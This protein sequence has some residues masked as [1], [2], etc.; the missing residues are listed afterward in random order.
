MVPSEAEASWV[1]P[2]SSLSIELVVANINAL[3]RPRTH[4]G[5]EESSVVSVFNE[6]S[7]LLSFVPATDRRSFA[8]DWPTLLPKFTAVVAFQPF[9]YPHVAT[10]IFKVSA[11]DFLRRL[12]QAHQHHEPVENKNGCS[13][14]A[15]LGHATLEGLLHLGLVHSAIDIAH[16]LRELETETA[17]KIDDDCASTFTPSNKVIA[18]LLHA[19]VELDGHELQS[20]VLTCHQ[21]FPGWLQHFSVT[22]DAVLL[23][24]ILRYAVF[25]SNSGL[26]KV[27]LHWYNVDR[28]SDNRADII[29]ALLLI[30]LENK[31]WS[32]AREMIASSTQLFSTLRPLWYSRILVSVAAELISFG[33]A[34][35]QMQSHP[36]VDLLGQL[37]AKAK[38]VESSAVLRDITCT[39]LGYLSTVHG[40]YD[41][42][43]TDLLNDMK[44]WAAS[45]PLMTS[46]SPMHFNVLLVATAKSESLELALELLNKW[47]GGPRSA[48]VS[49][50][51]RVAHLIPEDIPRY[52]VVEVTCA[53]R[54]LR[55]RG[56]VSVSLP[57][58]R[59]FLEDGT[60][61]I[62]GL[63]IEVMKKAGITHAQIAEELAHWDISPSIPQD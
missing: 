5:F 61:S 40:R 29:C 51:M 35:L 57:F 41:G 54:D 44:S 59:P 58:F 37:I 34:D 42:L 1:I 36:A 16:Q 62:S 14:L 3:L 7:I 48:G 39:I 23:P 31:E 15:R 24:A 45:S 10:H 2:S 38:L 26:A 32:K 30:Q 28:L 22:D 52:D 18:K 21:G 9:D 13:A 55:F 4:D 56:K 12:D 33:K 49:M 27:V 50:D 20:N 25:T 8:V 11:K 60:G 47:S 17:R 19:V 46:L 43:V 53:G 63:A 6:L